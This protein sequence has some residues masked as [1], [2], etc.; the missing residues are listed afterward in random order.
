MV[1]GT[2]TPYG[3]VLRAGWLALPGG[4]PAAE[5][6]D[7]EQGQGAEQDV[8]QRDGDDPPE[9]HDGDPRAEGDG[10]PVNAVLQASG[11]ATTIGDSW[12]DAGVLALAM[13]VSAL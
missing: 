10:G 4:S 8:S 5:E 12:Y 1:G 6:V 11:W 9:G 13:F 7:A 3:G 2:L